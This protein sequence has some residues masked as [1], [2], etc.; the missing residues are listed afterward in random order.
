MYSMSSSLLSEIIQVGSIGCKCYLL[1]LLRF[2]RRRR[3]CPL[4]MLTSFAL[5]YRLQLNL[6]YSSVNHTR[7]LCYM[8]MVVGVIES[9]L[10]TRG[11]NGFDRRRCR[12]SSTSLADTTLQI[13]MQR[14]DDKTFPHALERKVVLAGGTQST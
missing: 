12:R 8:R 6:Y 2:L 3:Y 13:K 4:W 9:W 1:A 7:C 10:V 5:L 14:F 11:G